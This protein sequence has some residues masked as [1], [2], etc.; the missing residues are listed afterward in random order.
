[1]R[2]ERLEGTTGGL[3][4]RSFV[5]GAATLTAAG[6]LASCGPVG[7]GMVEARADE[8]PKDEIFSGVCRGNC[9]GGCFLNV[10]VRDGQVVRTS[11]RD[12]PD[13]QYNRICCKGLT[14]VGRMYGADRIRYPM[15]RVGERGSGEF[16]RISWDEALDMIAEKWQGY[17]DEYGRSS[18]MFFMGSGNYSALSGSSNSI[19]AYQRFVNALGCSY[20][21][22]DV[23][24]GVGYGSARA[25]GGIRL[26]N[27]LTDR[28]NAKTQII[29]GNNPTISLMH[30][31]HF[32]LEAQEAGT[33]LIVIDPVYNSC[34]S[35]ADW[36]IPITAG[37][38]GALALGVLNVLFDRGWVTEETL[39]SKTN[40]CLLIKE[41]GSYLRE[42]DLGAK[43]GEDQPDRP[44]VWD[45]TAKKAMVLD[46]AGDPA[47][48]GV[49]EVEGIKVQTVFENAM[50]Y[51]S[52]YTP[53]VAAGICGLSED[54]V[55]ELARTYHEDGPVTTEVM[56]GMNHYRNAHYNSWP[57]WLV[58]HLTG[59]VGAPG[60]SIGASEEY[61]P[62]MV[63][64]NVAGATT[65]VDSKGNAGPGQANL[66]HTVQLDSLL[67]TGK[68]NGEDLVIK[69]AYIHCSNP[70]ATM[71]GHD[72]TKSWMSKVEFVV[73][74]DICMSETCKN[75]DLVLPSAHWFEQEDVG[76]LFSSHPYLLWQ[77]KCCEPLGESKPDFEIFGDILERLGLG[78]YWI[79]ADEYID[80]LFGTDYWRGLGYS[81]EEF[82]EKKA[83]RIYPE[84]DYICDA[85]PA[86]ETGRVQLYIDNP[87]PAYDAGQEI[88][89]S[90]EHGLHWESPKFAGKDREYRETYPYHMLSE[91]MRTHTHTQWSDCAYVREWEPEPIVR[92]NPDDAAELGVSEGDV[93]KCSNDNGYVVMKAVINAGL[94]RG[95]VSSGRSWEQRDFI[96]GHFASLPSHEYNPMVANQAFNDVAVAIEKM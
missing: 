88:D 96:E 54:D 76:C 34:S 11:A 47:L 42:S 7:L 29:W 43:I 71:A 1:M 90:I 4:R 60:A 20:C 75:A 44:L 28:K 52:Q 85:T 56:M 58:A 2:E 57:V 15:R 14:H 46:E 61:L 80:T 27:E 59:N 40:C 37:T 69:S 94:P 72:Y 12:M 25:D 83:L 26:N 31:M 87:T 51:I 70:V 50:G 3:T 36:W 93:V 86:T 49:G 91:H 62:Q 81:L 33:R 35:K 17:W 13:T 16:E 95:M 5:R 67:E 74:A 92:L 65:A 10:H 55:I 38:D 84:G 41:D 48:E 32:F 78:D 30:T 64:S 23:D 45:A 77:D 24:V 21:S 19:G 63:F 22:L 39:R 8:A 66:L 82:K 6:A 9:G 18:V 68:L 73:A 79:S 53:D 89:L